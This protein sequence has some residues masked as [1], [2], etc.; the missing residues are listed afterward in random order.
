LAWAAPKAFRDL[1]GSQPLLLR[2]NGKLSVIGQQQVKV[3]G[4]PIGSR[5]NVAA[6]QH[7]GAAVKLDRHPCHV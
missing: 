2:R 5:W 4:Q 6:G 3:A 1:P 7:A